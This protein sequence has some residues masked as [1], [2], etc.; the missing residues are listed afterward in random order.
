MH[1]WAV[2]LQI[3]QTKKKFGYFPVFNSQTDRQTDT[4]KICDG[5][6]YSFKPIN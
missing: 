1:F 3:S 6:A 4:Q 2:I 5:E